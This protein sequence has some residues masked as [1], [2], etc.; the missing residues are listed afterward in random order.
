MEYLYYQTGTSEQIVVLRKEQ[1]AE[2]GVT[3]NLQKLDQTAFN[4]LWVGR[5]PKFEVGNGWPTT[6]LTPNDFFY[7]HLHS[8]S[9]QNRWHVND[10]Q[11]DEWADQQKVE[12]D[13]EARREILRNI[14]DREQSEVLRIPNPNTFVMNIYQPWLRNIRFGGTLQSIIAFYD[15]GPQ[16]HKVWLDK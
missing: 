9:P 15:W 14:W 10:P 4:A 3:M 12:L 1:L 11:I 7:S 13:P 8:S 16:M 5:D 2:V 6:G